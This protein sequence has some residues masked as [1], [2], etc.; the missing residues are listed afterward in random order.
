MYLMTLPSGAVQLVRLHVLDARKWAVI[1]RSREDNVDSM[2]GCH[3]KL[4]LKPRTLIAS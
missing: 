1:A 3:R 4:E 2:V